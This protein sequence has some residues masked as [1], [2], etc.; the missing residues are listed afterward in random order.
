V[1]ETANVGPTPGISC[2]GRASNFGAGADLVSFIPLFDDVLAS[3]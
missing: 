2:N 3:L 1:L